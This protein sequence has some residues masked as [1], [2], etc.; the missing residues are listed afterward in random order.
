M[1]QREFY[2]QPNPVV[3]YD[4]G[5]VVLPCLLGGCRTRTMN[6]DEQMLEW[7][8]SCQRRVT[9]VGISRPRR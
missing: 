3:E 8:A 7:L 2:E 5:L 1:G 6:R 4:G 9:L